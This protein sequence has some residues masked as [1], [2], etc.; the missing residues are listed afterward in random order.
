M[1]A[2][3][4]SLAQQANAVRTVARRECLKAIKMRESET[5]MLMAHL[6]AAA[7]TLNDLADKECRDRTAK[8]PVSRA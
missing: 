2:R 8:A 5:D 7:D 1:S 3:P 4:I 6:R